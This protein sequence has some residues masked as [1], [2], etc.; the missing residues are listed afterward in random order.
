[1]NMYFAQLEKLK[2]KG[3]EN[4]AHLTLGFMWPCNY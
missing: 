2:D 1:M 3:L 4:V